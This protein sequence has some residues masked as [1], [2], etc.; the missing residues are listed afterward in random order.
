MKPYIAVAIPF[1][2]STSYDS[3]YGV[4]V[5]GVLGPG[6]YAW[7]MGSDYGDCLYMA[8]DLVATI[9]DEDHSQVVVKLTFCETG[10]PCPTC[11]LAGGFHDEKVHTRIVIPW[12]KIKAKGWQLDGQR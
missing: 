2:D 7:T 10:C 6:T 3:S 8:R 9:L 5:F 4:T 11:G 12:N 1:Y